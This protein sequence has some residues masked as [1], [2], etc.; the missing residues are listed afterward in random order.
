M[1][2]VPL[3]IAFILIENSFQASNSYSNIM[4][5]HLSQNSAHLRKLSLIS[6]S[7]LSEISDFE[8]DRLS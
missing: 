7:I 8:D 2:V 6:S 3:D 4:E 5:N 1:K